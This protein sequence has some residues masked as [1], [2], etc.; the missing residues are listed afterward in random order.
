MLSNDSTRF[1]KACISTTQK[2][3]RE[4]TCTIASGDY[5]T[6]VSQR[7]RNFLPKAT[8]AK[9]KQGFGLPF[10]IW[11]SS[12]KELKQFAV[13][14]LESIEKRGFL[15]PAY[16]KNLIRLHQEGHASYY[17]I[18]IWLLIMLEQWLSTH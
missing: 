15:N 10:G 7:L 16:I 4:N 1:R 18:M 13:A 3:L 5:S 12:D 8:L 2:T 14:S 6:P 9:S 11:M 17:G